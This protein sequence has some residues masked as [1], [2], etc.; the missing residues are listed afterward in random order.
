MEGKY[1]LLAK[2]LG[3]SFRTLPDV[4][5][6]LSEEKVKQKVQSLE[7]R[8]VL[9]KN[10]FKTKITEIRNIIHVVDTRINGLKELLEELCNSLHFSAS[11]KISFLIC[12]I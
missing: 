3:Q 11:K 1:E 4:I 8:A 7:Q 6:P 9:T 12:K 5:S 10:E 2:K